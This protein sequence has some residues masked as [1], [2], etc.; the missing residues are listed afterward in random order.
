MIL[1][2]LYNLQKHWDFFFENITYSVIGHVF[3]RETD[4]FYPSKTVKFYIFFSGF[5]DLFKTEKIFS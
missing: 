2:S 5:D 3:F 4:N 1:I